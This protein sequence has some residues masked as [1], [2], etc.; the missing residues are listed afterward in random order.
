MAKQ[1]ELYRIETPVFTSSGFDL[2]LEILR[3][4]H[5]SAVAFQVAQEL[6]VYLK[7]SGGQNQFADIPKAQFAEDKELSR[8]I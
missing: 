1:G 3:R 2:A 8:L 7:R 5:G 6:V 4:D